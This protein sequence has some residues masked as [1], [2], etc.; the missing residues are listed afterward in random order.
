[1]LDNHPGDHH[2]H[3][4]TADRDGGCHAHSP[5]RVGAG[6]S[7]RHKRAQAHGA[8]LQAAGPESPGNESAARGPEFQTQGISFGSQRI[9]PPAS[10]A[11]NS[12]RRMKNMDDKDADPFHAVETELVIALYIAVDGAVRADGLLDV[13]KLDEYSPKDAEAL[14]VQR[15]REFWHHTESCTRCE[16]IIGTLNM[17]RGTLSEGAEDFDEQPRMAGADAIDHIP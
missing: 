15:L 2:H 12:P 11:H 17:V 3:L 8:R 13:D 5:A 16:L 9:N 4:R 7:N 6:E 14:N 1:M 10:L